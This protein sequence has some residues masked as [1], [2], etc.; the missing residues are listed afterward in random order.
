M[1]EANLSILKI[2]VMDKEKQDAI[3]KINSRIGFLLIIGLIISAYIGITN[4]Y[5]ANIIN[6]WQAKQMN[7]KYFLYLPI[8]LLFLIE[9]IPLFILRSLMIF[10][11]N[12]KYSTQKDKQLPYIGK[13]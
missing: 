4:S 12:K 6:L 9:M 2:V 1:F 3:D 7:G 13:L 11:H 8:L 5:P 10:I